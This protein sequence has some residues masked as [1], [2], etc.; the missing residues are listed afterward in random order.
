[1]RGW[2]R[3]GADQAGRIRRGRGYGFRA[4]GGQ[5]FHVDD[6]AARGY[7]CDWS[8]S[9]PRTKVAAMKPSDVASG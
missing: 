1:M 9:W 7:G 4:C 5:P 2:V 3:L 8:R 6:L